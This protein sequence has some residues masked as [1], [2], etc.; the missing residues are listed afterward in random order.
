MRMLDLWKEINMLRTILT[1]AALT[2]TF[3]APAV[4]TTVT[5]EVLA[6]YVSAPG[7]TLPVTTTAAGVTQATLHAD[8]A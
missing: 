8:R 3:A 1:V 5:S 2:A 6:T 4:A 7:A